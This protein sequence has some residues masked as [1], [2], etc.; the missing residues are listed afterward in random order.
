M[1]TSA[2]LF[3]LMN[4]CFINGIVLN[5]PEPKVEL[6][7]VSSVS[8]VSS[9]PS[10]SSNRN[11]SDMILVFGY[12]FDN[13]SIQSNET[14]KEIMN[15][16]GGLCELCTFV[17][18]TVNSTLLQNPKVIEI[19]TE[20]IENVCK[21]LPASIQNLCMEAAQKEAPALLEMLGNY[22][23][24]DGC[25]ELKLCDSEDLLHHMIPPIH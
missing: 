4:L 22:L 2:T 24:N 12:H 20:G 17:V 1:K 8:S 7:S 19:A 3:L 18:D 11:D 16:G 23:V 15:E 5:T 21:V 10:N 13:K 6:S 9:I 14:I 25:K